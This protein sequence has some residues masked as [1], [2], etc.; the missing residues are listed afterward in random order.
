MRLVERGIKVERTL[1]RLIESELRCLLLIERTLLTE[2]GWPTNE[3]RELLAWLK[4][5]RESLPCKT[6]LLTE[7]P[8]LLAQEST[9]LAEKLPGLLNALAEQGTTGLRCLLLAC[10]ISTLE[11]DHTLRQCPLLALNGRTLSNT[12]PATTELTQA[13]SLPAD[14]RVDLFIELLRQNIAELLGLRC[15]QFSIATGLLLQLRQEWISLRRLPE[16]PGL[17][18]QGTGLL[19]ELPG[20]PTQATK[21]RLQ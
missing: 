1:L 16:L 3:L 6:G 15:H 18:T 10:H 21:L 19:T 11:T 7:K 8:L 9:L 12:L 5:G 2:H 14:G 4:S 17:A 13:S 20:L